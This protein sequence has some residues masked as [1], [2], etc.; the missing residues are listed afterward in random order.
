MTFG[1]GYGDDIGKAKKVID[2]VLKTD[3]MR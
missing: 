1:I 3:G 2:G